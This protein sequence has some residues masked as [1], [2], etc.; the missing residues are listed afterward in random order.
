MTLRHTCITAISK[1]AAHS[2]HQ[3]KLISNKCCFKV[4]LKINSEGA[5]F[6][7]I[8][9]WFQ[10]FGAQAEKAR[11]PKDFS[12]VEGVSSKNLLLDLRSRVC[13]Y[14][15]KRS[16]RYRGA[17]SFIALKV[18]R[19]ALYWILYFTGSQCKAFR[20]DVMCCRLQLIV[21]MRAAEFCT[22]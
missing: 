1:Q 15:C 4:F 16:W 21:T 6:I 13:L 10:S 18:R 19:S 8:G 14:G 7:W 17:M 2:T 5:C 22:I 9:N 3:L 11:S 20:T 12:F